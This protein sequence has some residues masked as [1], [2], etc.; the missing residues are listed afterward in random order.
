MLSDKS[1]DLRC[2]L[3]GF[4]AGVLLPAS[5]ILAPGASAD[6]NPAEQ[7]APA[8]DAAPLEVPAE[9]APEAPIVLQAAHVEPHPEMLPPGD[10]PEHGLQTK[11]ILA[12]RSISAEFPQITNMIGVRPDAKRWHPQGL[13]VDVIIPNPGSAEGIALGDEILAYALRNAERFAIQD[14]IWR[15]VYY[16]PAGP[17]GSGYGHYDHVHITTTGGGYP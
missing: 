10:C 17:R 8:V 9:P 4:A 12:A 3:I 11:T 15:G 5:F 1:R 16:T 14:V 2:K 7:P 6:P 13:A